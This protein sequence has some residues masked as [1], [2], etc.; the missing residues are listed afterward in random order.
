MEKGGELHCRTRRR[1]RRRGSLRS[2]R[3]GGV[4]G[5]FVEG[6]GGGCG[7]RVW[8]AIGGVGEEGQSYQGN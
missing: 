6:E 4:R 8:E 1:G 3:E 7:L 2:G 5:G